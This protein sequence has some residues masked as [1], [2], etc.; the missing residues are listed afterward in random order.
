[1]TAESQRA[2]A[3]A[4]DKASATERDRGATAFRTS[5]LVAAEFADPQRRVLW[6]I[7]GGYRIETSTD[8]TNWTERHR[9]PAGGLAVG[10]APSTGVAWAAGARGLVLRYVAPGPWMRVSRPIEDT[11]VSITASSADVARV[12]TVSGLQFETRDA[13]TT[14]TRVP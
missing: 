9:E 12:C 2:A 10:T 7:A 8:G 14:W 1:M 13:G 4:S 5:N 11:I 6:R 3:A